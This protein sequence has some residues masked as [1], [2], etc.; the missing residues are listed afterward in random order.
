MAIAAT[1]FFAGLFPSLRSGEKIACFH[2]DE[3]MRKQQAVEVKFDS[4]MQLVCCHG[5]AAVLKAIEQANLI[6]QYRHARNKPNDRIA[7]SDVT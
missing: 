5:C 3:L 7:S 6:A 2:C 4:E 1:S